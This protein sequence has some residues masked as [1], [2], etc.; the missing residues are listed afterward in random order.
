MPLRTL[1]SRVDDARRHGTGLVPGLQKQELA[2]KGRL[3]APRAPAQGG[4]VL[5]QHALYRFFASDGALLYVGLT[6]RPEGRWP[7]HVEGQPWW[8]EVARIDL[9]TFPDRAAVALAEAAAIRLERPR[10]NI[11]FNGTGA[12]NWPSDEGHPAVAAGEAKK[13]TVWHCHCVRCDHR[14]TSEGDE[15]P[16]GCAN[17][18]A[19]HWWLKR[20]RGRPPKVTVARGRGGA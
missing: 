16:S 19:L 6:C 15:I 12:R 3:R 18:R 9:Q 8:T 13:V 4:A 20:G 17:C 14:W 2:L 1:R 10:Y 5:M 7:K 11:H